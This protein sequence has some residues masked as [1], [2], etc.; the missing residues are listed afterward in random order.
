MSVHRGSFL[1]VFLSRP[2]S[3][4]HALRSSISVSSLPP[5]HQT[6]SPFGSF[7]DSAWF[8]A[9]ESPAL[10]VPAVLELPLGRLGLMRGMASQHGS[11][12]AKGNIS[13]DISPPLAFRHPC[14]CRQ[15]HPGI[16]VLQRHGYPRELVSGLRGPFL[17][18]KLMTR[19]SEVRVVAPLL[20][21]PH[22]A[23]PHAGRR[24]HDRG[25]RDL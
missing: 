21:L 23:Q 6:I 12:K 25:N 7:S 15:S 19:K 5:P 8:R 13:I 3:S 24:E 22:L 20:G 18:A 14:S 17:G 11:L 2:V 16:G 4:T 1:H 10:H 9:Q